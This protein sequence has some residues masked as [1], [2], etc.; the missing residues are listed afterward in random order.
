MSETKE[1]EILCDCGKAIMVQR[2]SNAPL[3]AIS[4]RCTFCPDCF[5][6]ANSSWDYK[7]WYIYENRLSV[8]DIWKLSAKKKPFNKTLFRKL[9][10]ENGHA[11]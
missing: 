9:V 4:M 1:I 5:H 3:K 6:L 10:L 11:Y 2:D 7:E 8:Y